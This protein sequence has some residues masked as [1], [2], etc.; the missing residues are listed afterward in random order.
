MAAVTRY[1]P[2]ITGD[3]YVPPSALPL[4]PGTASW[5]VT[6]MGFLGSSRALLL[7]TSHPLVAAGVAQHSDYRRDP[8]GRALR[9]FDTVLKLAFG[10]PEVSRRQTARMER[11]HTPV[12]GTARDGRRYDARDRELGLWVWATLVGTALLAYERVHGRLQPHDRAR[13]YEEQKL[14]GEGCSIPRELMPDTLEDFEAYVDRVVAEELQATPEGQ[15]VARYTFRPEV[16]RLLGP[17]MGRFLRWTAAALF[18]PRV[19]AMYG[20]TW[21]AQRERRF[22]RFL[23]V[24]AVLDSLQ[25]DV[26]RTLP[27]RLAVEHDLLARLERRAAARR[28]S[29]GRR[30][31]SRGGPSTP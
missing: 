27:T 9:T 19:R 2:A 7:Q 15:D 13:Y 14:F 3:E 28:T 1:A 20:L 12:T 8:F 31:V 24:L 16:P 11:R 23:H 17:A 5:E 21:D 30:S 10:P 26:V 4:G 6:M 29:T 22:R 25:P 18:P